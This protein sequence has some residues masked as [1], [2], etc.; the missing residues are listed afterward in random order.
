VDG[1]GSLPRIGQ[2]L[3]GRGADIRGDQGVHGLRSDIR[4][5]LTCSCDLSHLCIK[6]SLLE[7][8]NFKCRQNVDFLDQEWRRILLSQ[9]LSNLCQNPGG[10]RVLVGLPVQFN[11][12][13]L[14]VFLQQGIGVL[15]E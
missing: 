15:A 4:S 7:R 2:G 12:F 9:L 6:N 5:S 13:H 8:V 3:V 14:L 11:G 1:F 10:L